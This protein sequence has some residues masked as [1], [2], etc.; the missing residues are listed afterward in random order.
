[1]KVCK[2][3]GV[4]HPTTMYGKDSSRKDGLRDV[5]KSCRK[6]EASDYYAE[7]RAAILAK[8]KQSYHAADGVNKLKVSQRQRERYFKNSYGLTV[9][10]LSQK[11]V[12][13]ENKCEIC[14]EEL[15]DHWWKRHV[16]HCHTTGK[17]RGILCNDCNRGLGGFRDSMF[18]LEKAIRYLEKHNDDTSPRKDTC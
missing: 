5:C 2:R 1:M 14:E 11:A 13:Q 3:C 17:V 15:S 10:Q 18:A 7:N 12:E 4:V 9:E 8:Q 16:D 6:T